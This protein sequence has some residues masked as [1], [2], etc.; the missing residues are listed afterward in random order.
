VAELARRQHGVVA[1]WQLD[2]L[3]FG[4]GAIAYR[5]RTGRLHRLHVGV[6]AVGHPL[7]SVRGRW[8]A[9]VLA[10]GPRAVLSHRSAAALWAIRPS[11]AH[12]IDV[13]V[14]SGTRGRRPG[15]RV[16]RTRR[17]DPEDRVTADGIPVTAVA[18]TLLDI[19]EVVPPADLERAIEAAEG[20]RLFDLRAVDEVI[21]RSNGRR[22]L[23][24]L[25]RALTDYRPIQMTRSELERRFLV[26]CRAVGLPPPATNAIVAG[27]E[28]DVV[29]HHARLIVELDSRGF[30]DTQ[31]AFERD[32]VRDAALLLAGYR[33]LRVTYRRLVH[34][35]QTVLRELRN[36]LAAR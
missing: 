26:L 15:I 36:L 5:V 8:M 34:S 19:A 24:P 10:H 3:G 11:A 2:R 14:P 28:V 22:G 16:H 4:P 33:V 7:V 27:F 35:P 9:A 29:W 18:R 21:A 12:R 25:R 6:Y 31:A 23:G 1:R 17:L 20:L 13:T 30:H 32:R